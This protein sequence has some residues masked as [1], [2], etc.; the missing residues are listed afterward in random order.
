MIKGRIW[1][2]GLKASILAHVMERLIPHNSVW[3]SRN[4]ANTPSPF[5]AACYRYGICSSSIGVVLLLTRSR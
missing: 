2:L 5:M 4:Q 1:E 3:Q